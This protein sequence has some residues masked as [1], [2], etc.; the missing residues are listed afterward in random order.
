MQVKAAAALSGVA[1]ALWFGGLVA[2]GAFVAPVVF[3]K[4]PAPLAADAM[5]VVFR[6]FDKAAMTCAAVVCLCEVWRA[7]VAPRVARI[8]MARAALGVVAGLL[9]VWGGASLSPRIEALHLGGAVRGLGDAGAELERVHHQAEA[10]AKAEVIL[11]AAY[12]VLGPL[13][14]RR[15]GAAETSRDPV[16]SSAK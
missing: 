2:L 9:A 3:S 15:R 13:G 7:A 16:A 8:D 6:R 14:G 11:L 12:L 4:V 5:T 1:A 10:A